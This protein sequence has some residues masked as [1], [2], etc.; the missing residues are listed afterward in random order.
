L[1]KGVACHS[2]AR[3]VPGVPGV[4]LTVRLD[5]VGTV[6]LA[7]VARDD[8]VGLAVNATEAGTPDA[9]EWF[10][11]QWWPDFVELIVHQA[12]WWILGALVLIWQSW[13]SPADVR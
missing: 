13:K 1:E 3:G 7:A 9:K 5:R 11:T 12:H 2:A 10:K 4:P 8:T 6:G